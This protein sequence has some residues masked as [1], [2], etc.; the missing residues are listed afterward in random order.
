MVKDDGPDIVIPQSVHAQRLADMIHR[1]I[2]EAKRIAIALG[3]VSSPKTR[4]RLVQIIKNGPRTIEDFLLR[5]EAKVGLYPLVFRDQL[6]DSGK[7]P[8]DMDDYL[9]S[10]AWRRKFSGRP[11]KDPVEWLAVRLVYWIQSFTGRPRWGDV[12]EIID[13]IFPD[14]DIP[15]QFAPHDGK[16][17][18]TYRRRRWIKEKVKRYCLRAQQFRPHEV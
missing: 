9:K 15:T 16:G 1:E 3:V 7:L 2:A 4:K 11:K 18:V 6:D 10:L 13:R 5:G 17:T 8:R 14:F 12:A